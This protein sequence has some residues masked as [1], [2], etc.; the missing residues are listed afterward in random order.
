VLTED[1]GAVLRREREVALR[2]EPKKPVTSRSASASGS[3]SGSGSSG[4]GRGERKAKAVVAELPEELLPVFEALRAWRAEQAREQG[5]PAY[6]IFHDA[7]LREIASLGPTSVA[8][9]GTISGIGEK[10]LATYGEG[11]LGVL[12]S[13]GGG[14][15]QETP[16][17]A[18][19]GT[20][21]AAREEGAGGADGSFDWPEDEPEPDYDDWA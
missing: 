1:S 14:T 15:S 13:L 11:V 9:L 17:T 5:V 10:K 2:K 21:G 19:P 6:V 20:A 12:A 16:P 4:S 18:S 8:E 7:T 3:G